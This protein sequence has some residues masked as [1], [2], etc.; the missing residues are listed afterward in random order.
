MHSPLHLDLGQYTR[1]ERRFLAITWAL[2]GI[3]C[4][5]IWWAMAHWSVPFHPLWIVG[6]TLLFA[7][8][9]TGLWAT[10]PRD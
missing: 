7:L 5:I 9:A 6:P 1:Q 2:I 10:H 4:V 8:V 3:K